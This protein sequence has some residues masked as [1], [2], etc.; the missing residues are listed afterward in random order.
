MVKLTLL[1]H[2]KKYLLV[3]RVN[4]II[5]MENIFQRSIDLK[6]VIQI[7]EKFFHQNI[8]KKSANL[9]KVMIIITNE[10]Q[11]ALITF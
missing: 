7:K 10:L 6:S 2:D 9:K 5:I 8:V 3:N 11:M 1:K 4:E